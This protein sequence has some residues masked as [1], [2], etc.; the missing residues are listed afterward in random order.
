[1]HIHW[2]WHSPSLFS[3]LS[4][5]ICFALA[6]VGALALLLVYSHINRQAA[7]V[8]TYF[9]LDSFSL[10]S[11]LLFISFICVARQRTRRRQPYCI[12]CA[13]STSLAQFL[14]MLFT[15][16]NIKWVYVA[17][18]ISRALF[19]DYL[20]MASS[21]NLIIYPSLHGHILYLVSFSIFPFLFAP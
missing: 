13:R 19:S 2:Y 20:H 21:L 18:A 6:L 1:M 15:N 16:I 10:D 8:H 17:I 5:F 14:I 7:H 4:L 11:F 3:T 9:Y 12:F